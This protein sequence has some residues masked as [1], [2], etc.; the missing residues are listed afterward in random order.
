[1]KMGSTAMQ[2]LSNIQLVALVSRL[3]VLLLVAKI[4]SIGV[5]WYLPSEGIELNA[6][7]SYQPIY[8]RVSFSNMLIDDK[9]D[10]Y[11]SHGGTG[12]GGAGGA[13]SK[14]GT[15]KSIDYLLLRGLYGSRFNGFIIIAKKSAPNETSIIA[16][17][18]EY[19]GYTLK[20]IELRDVILTKGAKEFKL[21]L[22][23]SDEKYASSVTLAISNTEDSAQ[24][25]VSRADIQKYSSDPSLIWKDIGIQEQK[26][27]DQLVGFKVTRVKRGSKMDTLG[28]QKGD[29][30]IKANNRALTS[31]NEVLKFYKEIDKI[32]T[33]ALTILRDNQ[34]KEIIYEIR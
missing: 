14:G 15:V 34:E 13:S 7:K 12:A 32:E 25:D 11:D 30:I 6:Q 3:L 8:Q 24:K 19:A 18:E 16:V 23:E 29:L 10:A 1:M 31:I 2:K 17:G 21:S 28:L 20:E 26:E 4:I 27:G 22:E 5:W 33:L 9:T